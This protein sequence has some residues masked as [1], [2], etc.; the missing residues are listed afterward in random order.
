MVCMLYTQC[1]NERGALKHEKQCLEPKVVS[2]FNFLKK[3]LAKTT[4]CQV[5][6]K[7]VLKDWL[8][9]AFLFYPKC[10]KVRLKTHF[11]F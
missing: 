7:T 10:I 11:I 8:T 1:R 4:V 9:D 5:I 2:I 3:K 6:L